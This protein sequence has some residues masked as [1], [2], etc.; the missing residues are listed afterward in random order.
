MFLFNVYLVDF[1]FVQ[2]H[3]LREKTNKHTNIYKLTIT[4]ITKSQLT[5][6]LNTG[7]RTDIAFSYHSDTLTQTHSVLIRSKQFFIREKVEKKIFLNLP[8][9]RFNFIYMQSIF[10]RF[11]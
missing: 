4:T 11:I 2:F 1:T 3:P 6:S 5:K 10:Y 7:G 8:Q 9:S